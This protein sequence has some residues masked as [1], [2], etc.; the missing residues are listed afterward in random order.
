MILLNCKK[1]SKPLLEPIMINNEMKKKEVVYQVFTRLF[2]NTN[3]TNKPWGTIEENG[4]GKFADFTEK[5]LKEIKDLGVTY[6]WYTGVPHHD[7]IRDYTEYGIS[8]DDPDVVKGRAGSPYA[9]KDY[10][11]V[12]P[13]LATNPENRLEEFK[14]LI[15]R[16][17]KA[18]L[19]V[20]I[21]IVPNHVA[22][23]YQS[24]TNPKGVEDFGASDNK[25]KVYHVNN[26]F[27]YNPGES[28]QVP[29]WRNGYLPLGGEKHPLLDH[30]FDENPAKWTGNG[31]RASQPDMEDWYETVKIN[32][33]VSPDGRKDFNELPNGF[34]N[35]DYKKHFKFWQD[36]SVPDSWIK[37]RDIALYWLDFGVDGFRFDMAEMVPVEF[38]SFMNSSIKMKNPETFL[39]A[40]VYNPNLYRDYIKKGKMDYLYDKVQLY[41]T[42]KHIMQGHGSTDHIPPIQDYLKDIEHQML[43][44]LE[45]HDEQRIASPEFVGNAKKGKPAMVVSATIS[46]SPTMIYF[47]QEVGEPGAEHGGHGSPSRTSIYDYVGVPNHQ[48]WV[49]NKNFDGGQST[50]EEKV[51]RDFYKRLLNFTINSSALMG[52]YQDIHHFNRQNTEWYNDKVLSFVRWNADEKLIVVSSFSDIDTF[53]FELQLPEDLVEKLNVKDGNHEVVDQLYGKYKSTLRIS[54]SKALVRIDIKPLESLILK[55]D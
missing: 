4:V 6:I 51:L 28:F 12:N 22:R 38:W 23:N 18:G 30:Q 20:I 3:T 55:I 32:Y 26:N 27:Y 39:L 10:Y 49:N 15:D 13:D 21:D 2:G 33:G 48:R 35:E 16:S 5:A 1:Q 11:N 14:Q 24:L 29:N 44:F 43:H 36:K 25:N 41:D 40:E 31:S 46:T 37:F 34:E 52:N 53:G 45:N 50:D 47:G 17:H 42:L 9:V 54:N 19:K 7:V 8:N